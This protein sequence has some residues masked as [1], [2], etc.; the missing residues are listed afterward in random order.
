[1]ADGNTRVEREAGVERKAGGPAPA[2]DGW[3]G[4]SSAPGTAAAPPDDADAPASLLPYP[5]RPV[6][7]ARYLVADHAVARYRVIVRYFFRQHERSRY[8]LTADEI[9]EH[10]RSVYRSDYTLDEC[11]R[12]LGQLVHWG[13]LHAEQ[14]RS[15]ARTVEEF[16]RRRLRYRLTPYT[17]ELERLLVRLEHPQRQGGSL[18]PAY[19]E[20]LWE[21]LRQ[22]DRLLSTRER[23]TGAITADRNP[24]QPALARPTGNGMGPIH[25]HPADR[26]LASDRPALPED[27]ADPRRVRALWREAVE[28]FTKTRDFANDYLSSLSAARPGTCSSSRHSSRTRTC[29]SST[30]A[31]SSR[32]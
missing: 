16:I 3:A 4:G 5:T 28:Y 12:D 15:R 11:E 18:D 30:C 7:E 14:E 26:S 8:W 2:I 22:L 24:S 32:V 21:R 9:V 27:T 10:V 6:D 31:G 19:L 25:V 1:M 29:W 13:N 20:G 23:A 17:V